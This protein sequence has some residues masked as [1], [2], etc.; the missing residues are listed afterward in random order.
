[1]LNDSLAFGFY[2]SMI[3]FFQNDFWK[4]LFVNNWEKQF[5]LSIIIIIIVSVKRKC[6]QT[7]YLYF[8]FSESCF[9]ALVCTKTKIV[10][11]Y[12]YAK[13]FLIEWFS[14]MTFDIKKYFWDIVRHITD[15]LWTTSERYLMNSCFAN[16]Y[17]YFILFFSTENFKWPKHP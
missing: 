7:K 5:L 11:I 16:F 9:W 3:F 15:R 4:N 14:H 8:Q 2:F 1:M 13:N 10:L 17:S 6:L 12:F